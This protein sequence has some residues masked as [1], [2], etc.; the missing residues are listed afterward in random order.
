M[1]CSWCLVI[2]RCVVLIFICCLIHIYIYL[3]T[4]Y[5]YIQLYTYKL[6]LWLAYQFLILSTVQKESNLF[7]AISLRREMSTKILAVPSRI[8]APLCKKTR[9]RILHRIFQ[10]ISRSHGFCFFMFFQSW[11]LVSYP[12]CHGVRPGHGELHSLLPSYPVRVHLAWP[13]RGLCGDLETGQVLMS[14]WNW[15][16]IGSP[17]E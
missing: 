9:H 17:L 11:C 14:W 4:I 10:L 15:N 12:K 8:P 7:P 5:I 13:Y 6:Y 2:S 1:E 3:H 16:E